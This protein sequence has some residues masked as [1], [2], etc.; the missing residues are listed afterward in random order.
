MERNLLKNKIEYGIGMI[1][2]IL[3]CILVLAPMLLMVVNSFKSNSE[4]LRNDSG[5]PEVWTQ[6]SYKSLFTT[7]SS[8]DKHY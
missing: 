4:M 8:L 7:Y 3:V 5:L 1:C 2:F 6:E